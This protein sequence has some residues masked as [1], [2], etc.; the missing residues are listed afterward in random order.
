MPTSAPLLTDTSDVDTD[1]VSSFQNVVLPPL[2]K[3][4][5]LRCLQQRHYPKLSCRSSHGYPSMEQVSLFAAA[6]YLNK[7]FVWRTLD[8]TQP[9]Y[10][11]STY[12]QTIIPSSDGERFTVVTEE[13]PFLSTPPMVMGRFTGSQ[14]E[15]PPLQACV[16]PSP[17]EPTPAD[18][19]DRHEAQYTGLPKP[20]RRSMFDILKLKGPYRSVPTRQYSILTLDEDPA[21]NA[22]DDQVRRVVSLKTTVAGEHRVRSFRRSLDGDFRVGNMD[23]APG[24]LDPAVLPKQTRG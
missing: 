2:L 22:P 4:K 12:T 5:S 14:N 24:L 20:F 9:P 10:P 15:V 18:D 7:T 3:S 11:R 6:T 16:S 17:R 8:A 19:S 21:D 23:N 1:E 13:D